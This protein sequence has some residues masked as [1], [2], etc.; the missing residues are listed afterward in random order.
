MKKIDSVFQHPFTCLVAGATQSGKSTFVANLL[1]NHRDYVNVTFDY[2]Y[3]FLGTDIKQNPTL[4]QIKTRFPKKTKIMDITS[5]YKNKKDMRESFPRAIERLVKKKKKS[6]GCFIFDDLMKEMGDS[7]VLSNIFI[8]HSSHGNVSVI[9]ITQ[10]LFHKG[11]NQTEGRTLYINS[12]IIVLFLNKLDNTTLCTIAQKITG[13]TDTK[14]LKQLLKKIQERYRYVVL[15]GHLS[16]PAELLITSDYFAT[17]PV[18]HFKAFSLK[19]A[20]E[21]TTTTRRRRIEK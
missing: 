10:N 18:P 20:E 6:K 8:K 12:H 4:G 3:I 19:D 9:F 1:L 14:R 11:K 5:M 21:T 7:D 13:G 16:T 17:H 15:R 2:I